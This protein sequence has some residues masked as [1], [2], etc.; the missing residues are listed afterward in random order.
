MTFSI[1][2][3]PTGVFAMKCTFYVQLAPRV[4]DANILLLALRCNVISF[5]WIFFF[6]PTKRIT[7]MAIRVSEI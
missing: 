7:T 5:W 1:S 6:V 4:S 2:D 3:Y